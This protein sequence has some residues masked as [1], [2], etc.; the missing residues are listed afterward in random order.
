MNQTQFKTCTKC[1]QE[2]DISAFYNRQYSGV[3]RTWCR[4]C[5]IDSGHWV[6][7]YKK[8]GTTD[9]RKNRQ[10]EYYQKNREKIK[11]Q[12]RQNYQDNREERLVAEKIKY[13]SNPEIRFKKGLTR[14]IKAT[15]LSTD[16]IYTWYN[17]QFAE[18]NGCCMICGLHESEFETR[19]HIDHNHETGKLRAL[20]C[21]NCNIGI[22]NFQ[23]DAELCLAAYS[24][25]R[26]N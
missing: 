1:K 4:Q 14:L 19:L 13:Y 8:F 11:V 25:L 2:K 20:L 12:M 5:V 23:D 24:Y 26:E 17:A 7:N 21:T 15:G 18:Q 9:A 16:E 6:E 22:G 10:R 3:D